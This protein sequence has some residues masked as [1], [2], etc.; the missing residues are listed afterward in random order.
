MKRIYRIIQDNNG[1]YF[2]QSKPIGFLY[3]LESWKKEYI[4]RTLL[5]IDSAKSCL[6]EYLE[7][8]QIERNKKIIKVIK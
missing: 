4:Y 6:N 5:T 3:F 7:K 2:I 1:E 8:E